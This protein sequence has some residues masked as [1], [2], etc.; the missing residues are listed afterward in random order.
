MAGKDNLDIRCCSNT[1]LR[2]SFFMR[3]SSPSLLFDKKMIS[4]RYNI[5]ITSAT[6][7]ISCF[8]IQ[9]HCFA[10]PSPKLLVPGTTKLCAAHRREDCRNDNDA[11]SR[12]HVLEK[13][14]ASILGAALPTIFAPSFLTPRAY[15]KCSDIDS[16]REEGE[17]K[18]EADLK[19][20]PIVRLSDGVQY[21]VL[22]SSPTSSSK[23]STTK[24][25][26]KGSN[27][28]LAYS[29]STA[30]GQYMYSKGFGFEKVDFGGGKQVSDLGLDSLNVVVMGG[31]K[32]QPNV[33]PVGIENALLG[34]KKGEKR[35]VELPPGVGFETS[36]WSPEPTTR[37]GK[38][39]IVQYKRKLTGFGSQ[40][41]FPAETVWDI[42]VLAVR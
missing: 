15:A 10:P 24:V 6:A 40:P 39:G 11:N 32:Q 4:R 18:V 22:R 8:A 28:D 19:L 27:I 34:M 20:N 29:I 30:S 12:R 31:G 5:I 2:L 16:C 14:A 35:R 25:V 41:P 17:R 7:F 36:N 9:I 38:A 33:V 42:E 13:S 26:T 1:S 23:S 37:M 3:T 21:R